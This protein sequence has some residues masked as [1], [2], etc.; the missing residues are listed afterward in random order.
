M[1]VLQAQRRWVEFA[2]NEKQPG[3]QSVQF[4]GNRH[5]MR[6]NNRS[7]VAEREYSVVGCEVSRWKALAGMRLV[8]KCG[9]REVAATVHGRRHVASFEPKR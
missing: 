9:R 6:V 4:V 3:R 8:G 5:N 1:D 7:S 2:W